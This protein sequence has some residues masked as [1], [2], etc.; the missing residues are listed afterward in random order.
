MRCLSW[1][2]PGRWGRV[3]VN[4]FQMRQAPKA[5]FQLHIDWRL[6]KASADRTPYGISREPWNT[7]YGAGPSDLSTCL[8]VDSQ[9]GCERRT[10]GRRPNN[11]FLVN[12]AFALTASVRASPLQPRLLPVGVMRPPPFSAIRGGLAVKELAPVPPSIRWQS[13]AKSSLPH[14][15][16]PG[17]RSRRRRSYSA[18]A[19]RPSTSRS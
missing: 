10:R 17:C 5:K 14:D 18:R 9:S 11:T 13:R 15:A 8:K 19:A 7:E 12:V 6:P 2:F 16:A 1:R 4:G 3:P